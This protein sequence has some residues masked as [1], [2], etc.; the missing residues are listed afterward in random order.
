[1]LMNKFNQLSIVIPVGS[2]ERA[3]RHLLNELAVFGD[4][5]EIILSACQ[6]Q[7]GDFELPANAR[8]LQGAQGRACQLNVG[9]REASKH[10]IWFLHADTRLT[11][12]VVTEMHRY[13]QI[14][15]HCLGYFRLRF[16]FDGPV[17]TCLNAWAANWRSRLFGLPFGDQGFVVDRFLFEQLNGF[18]EAVG[19]GEDLDFVVRLRA[20]GFELLELSAELITSARRYGQ[21]GWLATTIRHVRLTLRLTR[22]ARQRLAFA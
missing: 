12:G 1:M 19:L 17:L 16:A 3:W 8:W 14:G 21:H 4:N 13:L 6:P 9:T 20:A 15:G 7:P 18:D 10:F 5:I 2:D 11:R 22:E